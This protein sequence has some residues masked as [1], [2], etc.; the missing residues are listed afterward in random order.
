MKQYL[1]EIILAIAVIAILAFAIIAFNN[2]TQREQASLNTN[3]A[4]IPPHNHQAILTI[5][6]PELFQQ[7][8][9]SQKP[10]QRTLARHINPIFI[11]L[12]QNLELQ[13]AQIS[14]HPQGQ[15]ACLQTGR[16]TGAAERYIQQKLFPTYP[17]QEHSKNNIRYLY[18]PTANNTFFGYYVHNNIIVGSYSRKLLEAAAERHTATSAPR[19]SQYIAAQQSQTDKNAPANIILKIQHP[20]PLTSPEQ[21]EI[22]IAADIFASDKNICLHTKLTAN[23]PQNIDSI[24][25]FLANNL[26]EIPLTLQA[27]NDTAKTSLTACWQKTP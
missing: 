10:A 25:T 11:A 3:L 27:S 6:R 9:L 20:S 13:S 26:T 2:I 14:L 12:L 18:Y 24:A 4:A 7:M 8:I 17:P 5:N 15:L 22:W 16:A 1:R 19:P 21:P 23:S